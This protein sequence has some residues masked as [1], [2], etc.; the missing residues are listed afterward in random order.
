MEARQAPPLPKECSPAPLASPVPS[1][2]KC[3]SN[4]IG[5]REGEQ[6]QHLQFGLDTA[7]TPLLGENRDWRQP[8]R[9][10]QKSP[11]LSTGEKGF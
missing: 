9:K 2:D 10:E 3:I 8:W 11:E 4:H 5:R 7:I 1:G 6:Q